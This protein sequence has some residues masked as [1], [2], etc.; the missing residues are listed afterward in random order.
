MS[1]ILIYIFY[2]ALIIIIYLVGK[3]IF[4]WIINETT[5]VGKLVDAV[6]ILAAAMGA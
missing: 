1:T 5:T 2:I 3:G 4:E 6:T